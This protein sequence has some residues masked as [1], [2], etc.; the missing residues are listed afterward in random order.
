MQGD[1]S[2]G[3]E[4]RGRGQEEPRKI[5]QDRGLSQMS[6]DNRYVV[7]KMLKDHSFASQ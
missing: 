2:Y 1:W 3:D 7:N 6:L 4:G 5:L